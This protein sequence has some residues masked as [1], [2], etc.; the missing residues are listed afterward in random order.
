MTL[1]A[2]TLTI[3][4]VVIWILCILTGMGI[5]LLGGG[6]LG[7]LFGWMI[8]GSIDE[9]IIKGGRVGR[10]IGRLLGAALGTGL[11]IFGAFQATAIVTHALSLI[12]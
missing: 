9:N 5:G 4:T 1:W 3:I 11:G 8:A 12:H 6:L 7:R 2:S 10:Q